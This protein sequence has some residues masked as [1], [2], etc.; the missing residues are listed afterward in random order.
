[1]N[2]NLAKG[3]VFEVFAAAVMGGIALSGGRGSLIGAI[4]GVLFLGCISSILTWLRV[5]PFLVQTVR[6]CV[7]LFAIVLDALKKKVRERML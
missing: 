6:G 7:I 4:G 5:S 1:V 3:Q 2:N